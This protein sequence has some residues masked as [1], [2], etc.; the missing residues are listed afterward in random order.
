M[1]TYAGQPEDQLIRFSVQV[2]YNASS[3]L[4]QTLIATVPN[5][6]IWE[7]QKMIIVN[8]DGNSSET[9]VLADYDALINDA[10]SA[11]QGKNGIYEYLGAAPFTTPTNSVGF[12]ILEADYGYTTASQ[13]TG[14]QIQKVTTLKDH[15]LGW[16]I[17]P[18]AKIIFNITVDGFTPSSQE[19]ADVHLFFKKRIYVA[20]S[21]ST[22]TALE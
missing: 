13:G 1:A 15:T 14:D 19:F 21:V 12:Q 4:S 16:K 11:G 7:L 10:G 22:F 9:C 20:S 2:G 6:Q 8:Q 17:Y 5:G 18:Q 3:A